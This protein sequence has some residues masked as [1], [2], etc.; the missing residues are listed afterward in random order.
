M[1][2]T[3]VVKFMKQAANEF[4]AAIAA[5]EKARQKQIADANTKFTQVTGKKPVISNTQANQILDDQVRRQT[6]EASRKYKEQEKLFSDFKAEENAKRDARVA[7]T[8]ATIAAQE[9]ADRIRRQR[10]MSGTTS[11]RPDTLH[12]S[13]STAGKRMGAVEAERAKA[14]REF[15]IRDAQRQ[16]AAFANGTMKTRGSGSMTVGGKTTS[17]GQPIQRDANGQA[18]RQP[19]NN[20]KPV[21][22]SIIN[23]MVYDHFADGS[24]RQNQALTEQYATTGQKPVLIQNHQRQQVRRPVQQRPAVA[25]ANNMQQTQTVRL[26]PTA[27]PVQQSATTR[28]NISANTGTVGS[29]ATVGTKAKPASVRR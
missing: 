5:Q 3:D 29:K 26:Q 23:G 16:D 12:A 25:P 15:Q 24:Q 14:N 17:F 11:T 27:R 6:E 8:N 19:A 13:P 21:R 4:D 28:T 7:R 18:I 2:Y 9:K 22:Q 20:A 10:E 1:K